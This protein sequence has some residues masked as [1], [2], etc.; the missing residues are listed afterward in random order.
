MCMWGCVNVCE[1][2]GVGLGWGGGRFQCLRIF[3][4]FS[5]LLIVHCE[6]TIITTVWGRALSK[7]HMLLPRSFVMYPLMA[8]CG[9]EKIVSYCCFKGRQSPPPPWKGTLRSAYRQRWLFR[10]MASSVFH[11]VFVWAT[12]GRSVIRLHLQTTPYLFLNTG[13]RHESIHDHKEAAE[14]T[15]EIFMFTRW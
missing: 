6:P 2:R 14:E 3:S 5:L 12:R 11:Q 1:N 9:Q 7:V 4:L 8:G 13:K 10:D 15:K